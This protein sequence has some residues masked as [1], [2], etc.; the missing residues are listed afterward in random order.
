MRGDKTSELESVS[1]FDHLEVGVFEE[2]F[3]SNEENESSPSHL[4]LADRRKLLCNSILTS[5]GNHRARRCCCCSCGANIRNRNQYLCA[6]SSSHL[7]L[8]QSSKHAAINNMPAFLIECKYFRGLW[9]FAQSIAINN[10]NR[11]AARS[12]CT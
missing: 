8:V 10:N 1:S 4:Q 6:L 5:R 11:A 12:S 7:R 3:V 9:P 2:H